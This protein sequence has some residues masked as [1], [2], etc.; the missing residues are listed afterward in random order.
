MGGAALL[1]LA[2]FL[3]HLWLKRRK[4][5]DARAEW[6]KPELSATAVSYPQP[7][8]LNVGLPSELRANSESPTELA[9]HSRHELY[10]DLGGSEMMVAGVGWK[11]T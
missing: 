8:Y 11:G 2:A 7:R 5:K 6:S 3:R 9:D 1:A 4:K 10:G